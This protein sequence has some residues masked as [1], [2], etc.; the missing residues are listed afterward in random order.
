MATT[1]HKVQKVVFNPVNQKIV[2]FLDEFQKLAKDA[3]GTAAHAIIEQF[4]YTKMPPHL[5]KNEK[6]NKSGPLEE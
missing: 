4:I 1:K 6:I 3:F 2:D 5:K